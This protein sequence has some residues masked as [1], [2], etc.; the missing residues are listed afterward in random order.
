MACFGFYTYLIVRTTLMIQLLITDD[1]KVL[2]D[3]FISLFK[4]LDEVTVVATANDGYESL[5]MLGQHKVDVVLMDINMPNLNG[6]ETCK[7]ISEQF[8]DVKVIALSMYKQSSYVNKMKMNGAKGYLLKDDTSEEIIEA[9]KAVYVGKEYYSRQIKEILS[10]PSLEEIELDTST[11]TRRETE[12]LNLIS[13]G[14]STK[15]IGEKLFIS[16]H[17]VESHR[18]NLLFKFKAKNTASLVKKAMDIGLL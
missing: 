13:E 12:I 11:I 4:D 6:V 8:P 17:T 15:L 3:G 10:N 14:L 1:H 9:I 7:I 16:A 18:K 5:N 2:L